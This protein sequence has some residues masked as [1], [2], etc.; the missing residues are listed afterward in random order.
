MK[1][2]ASSLSDGRCEFVVWAPAAEEVAL[3]LLGAKER[4]LPMAPEERGYWRLTVEDAYPGGRY[5]YR[6]DGKTDRPD[7]ASRFQPE[8]VHGPSAVV[9]HGA[10]RLDRRG[11]ARAPAGGADPLRAAR[12]HLHPRGNLRCRHPAARRSLRELGVTAIELMPVAQFP[13]TRNWGYD[14]VHPFA[15]QNTYG[16]PEGLQRL[17]DACHDRGLA[18][19]L[20]VVYNHL[21]PEGNYL[22]RIRPLLHRPL[23]HPVG[24]GDQL[25]RRR[26]RRG[27]P[28]LHRKRPALVR[29]STT[30]TPCGSTPSTPSSTSPPATSSQELAG[31]GR[32]PGR[33]AAAPPM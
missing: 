19:V 2:G 29:A 15:A 1:I 4:L 7:P 9:D 33:A 25:R 26:Q 8:G 31:A 27:A 21:G 28:L 30:S 14:G 24:R 3:R 32:S 6:L 17:V 22:R 13:G 5:Y 10:L 18:V 23:P 16:G 12:R 20:D 11:L